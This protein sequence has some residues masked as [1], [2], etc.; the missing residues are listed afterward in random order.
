MQSRVFAA[1]FLLL[2]SWSAGA[3][4]DT[5]PSLVIDR[6][7]Q[8]YVVATDGSYRLTVDHAKSI[9]QQRAVQ[10]HSQYY[11]A[12]NRTLDSVD[13]ITAYTRKAGGRRVP[14]RPEQIKDQQEAASSEAPMFQDTR[15]KIIVFPDI[16]AGDQL[17]VHYVL[18]RHTPLF[19]GH[20]DD[21][22]SS[23]FYAN[24]QFTLIYDMPES[25][26]LYADAIGFVPV[27]IAS[28]PGRKRYQW[29]YVDGTNP[30]A[31]AGSVSYF[32]YGKRLAVST[33]ATYADLARAYQQGSTGK[34]SPT[35]TITQ[36]A[37]QITAG[38][39]GPRAKALALA[40][41][42][43]QH[44]R[45]VG[46]YIG[47]GGVVPHA[48]ATVL[49]N[50]YG[51]CKDHAIL[52]EALLHAAGIDSTAV[53][54]NSGNAFRLPATPTLG[55]FNHVITY[56][57][58][59]DLYLDSTAESIAAGYLPSGVMD[60]PV[61]LVKSAMLA[62]TPSR[63][64]ERNRTFT[65]FNVHADGHSSFS[66]A[67]INEGAIAEPYRQ[68]V[69]DTKEADRQLFVEQMLQGLGQRGHGVFEAGKLDGTG[70]EYSMR[71]NGSSDN[72]ANLPGPVGLATSF[73]LWGGMGE[74]VFAL[75]QERE[76]TQAFA[77]PDID[78]EDETGYS[79]PDSVNI[80]AMPRPVSLR[81][82]NVDYR[83]A[84]TRRGNVVIAQRHLTFR[85]E[86]I[87]CT[88]ADYERLQPMLDRIM[89]DLKS[90]VIIG[91]Q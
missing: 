74:T 59:L 87:V 54:V 24:P 71:L 66:M 29:R 72:F 21:L 35:S 68:A 73:N 91:A 14:V 15:M 28:A 7:I 84:Y 33:F 30:R 36:L 60:K 61:L 3:A 42:V 13:A 67:K 88:A 4:D 12:Y 81:D 82:D 47:P 43:R 83:A 34:S 77:C 11:I 63:Q 57:P 64:H 52:L 25:M 45:Y 32:D 37:A 8:H 16:E 10:D 38:V 9:R 20:F 80:I 70:D 55:I 5:D 19:A 18:R 90:Q 6:Y 17:V 22:S 46:V 58:S 40:N 76:R 79:F 23:Q 78:M 1:L 41:W 89:R 48:A 51:D 26:P 69:R 56:V 62:R 44:I 2:V 49:A 85:H 39:Q 65:W 53:L 50:R 31:E 86:G 27:S 75:G